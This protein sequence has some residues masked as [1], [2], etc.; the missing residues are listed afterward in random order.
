MG[1]F[2]N[3]NGHRQTVGDG[4]SAFATASVALASRN[5]T[6]TSEVN[7]YSTAF[8]GGPGVSFLVCDCMLHSRLNHRIVALLTSPWK[9]ALLEGRWD[10]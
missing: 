2:L 10:M 7:Y 9:N 8:S 5:Q 4:A 6:A 3:S 1:F